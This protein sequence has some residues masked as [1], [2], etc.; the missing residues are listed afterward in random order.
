MPREIP[1]LSPELVRAFHRCMLYAPP[2]RLSR[3]LRTMFIEYIAHNRD[4][5]PPDFDGWVD[6]LSLLFGLLDIAIK[7]TKGWHDE[8]VIS[9]SEGMK[10]G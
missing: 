6:D 7:E 10:V 8:E 5:L 3:C 4:F 2:E 1:A 9:V